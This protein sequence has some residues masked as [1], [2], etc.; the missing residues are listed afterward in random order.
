MSLKKILLISLIIITN[1][2]KKSKPKICEIKIDS[3]F[4]PNMA[5][6]YSY[7]LITSTS[8]NND[9]V[10]F[11]PFYNTTKQNYCNNWY[12]LDK[13]SACKKNTDKTKRQP[14]KDDY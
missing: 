8:K 4:K 1:S 11:P 5:S 3:A 12:I 7:K 6:L 10:F 14:Y 13:K 9:Y 2:C